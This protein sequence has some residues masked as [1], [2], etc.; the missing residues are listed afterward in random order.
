VTVHR[1]N[2]DTDRCVCGG[3]VVYFEDG[4][5]D[6]EVGEGCEVSDAVFPPKCV[7]CGERIVGDDKA[8]M[9]DPSADLVLVEMGKADGIV[10]AE[11]GLARGWGSLVTAYACRRAACPGEVLGRAARPSTSCLQREGSAPP[12]V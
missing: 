2:V 8:E 6:G 3:I 12:P 10:H 4:D 1:F 7:I 9:Y 11:C 5:K